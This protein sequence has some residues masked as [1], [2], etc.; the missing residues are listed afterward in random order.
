MICDYEVLYI[1]IYSIYVIYNV[2]MCIPKAS[3]ILRS[4]QVSMACGIIMDDR[5]ALLVR[6]LS[7]RTMA[8]VQGLF[9]MVFG[10]TMLTLL[11]EAQV[12]PRR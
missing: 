7:S 5:S 3:L 10:A 9:A 2:Y 1:I 6:H 11:S 12:F 8:M 4:G